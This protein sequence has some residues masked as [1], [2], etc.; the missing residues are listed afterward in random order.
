M[1]RARRH[2]DHV[3]AGEELRSAVQGFAGG[4]LFGVPLLYTMEI[5]WLGDHTTAP[6]MLVVL[7]VTAAVVF[8][9]NLTGGF[10]GRKHAGLDN[11]AMDSIEALGI[12]VVS[13]AA[14]LALLHRIGPGIPAPASLA[15]IVYEAMPFAI[16]VSLARQLLAGDRTGGAERR[17]RPRPPRSV[18]EETAADLSAAAVGALLVAFNI[19]PTDE[20]DM[21]SAALGPA[22]LAAIVAASLAVSYAIVFAAEFADHEHR[23]RQEGLLQRP[24][25]ETLASYAVALGMSGLMLFI[26]QNLS[27]ADPWENHAAKIIVLGLPAAVGGAA[28]RLAV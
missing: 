8:L 25:S 24:L 23:H 26:F 16:G 15:K 17:R 22:S 9:L 3:S 7:I 5:W 14:I 21:L 20:I 4:M 1:A 10:K 11:V 27:A 12:G 28:G 19:A 6:Q 13:A 2:R 18:G